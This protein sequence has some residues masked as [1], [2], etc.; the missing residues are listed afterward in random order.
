MALF[1]PPTTVVF[2]WPL[3]MVCSTITTVISAFML[4]PVASMLVSA[5]TALMECMV[6]EQYIA[7]IIGILVGSCW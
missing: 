7:C 4:I 1:T 6:N 5:F 2:K 3:M